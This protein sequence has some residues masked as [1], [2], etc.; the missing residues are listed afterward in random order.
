MAAGRTHPSGGSDG[1]ATAPADSAPGER[2]GQAKGPG[3]SGGDE[4]GPARRAADPRGSSRST[5][6][7][8]KSSEGG[9]GSDEGGAET[10]AS[11]RL[12]G[13]ERGPKVREGGG[14]GGRRGGGRAE[15]TSARA[16]AAA[17]ARRVTGDGGGYDGASGRRRVGAPVA[18]GRAT[19]GRDDDTLCSLFILHTSQ[20]LQS[21]SIHLIS[22]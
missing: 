10:V 3:A 14:W 12:R 8:T 16:R 6:G 17:A 19:Q 9:T 4:A 15:P 18:P 7:S 22:T 5:F 13:I 11:S 2:R 1:V 21:F 20:L